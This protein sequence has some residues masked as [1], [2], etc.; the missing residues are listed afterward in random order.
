M[1]ELVT[2]RHGMKMG[3]VYVLGDSPLV[4][5]TA[6][7]T[8]FEPA[9]ASTFFDTRPCPRLLEDGRYAPR[10]D[11]RPLQVVTLLDNRT[12]LEDLYAKLALHAASA[13]DD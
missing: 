13:A 11:G 2:I 9:P 4:L 7:W 6:L 10:P 1:I 12:L 3:E 5:L 8:A